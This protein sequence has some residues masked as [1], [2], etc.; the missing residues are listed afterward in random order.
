M[1]V[2]FPCQLGALIQCVS[3]YVN[4]YRFISGCIELFQLYQTVWNRSNLR[5]KF[6]IRFC[7]NKLINLQAFLMGLFEQPRRNAILSNLTD[8]KVISI[9]ASLTFAIC[10]IILYRFLLC[11]KKHVVN[12]K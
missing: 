6:F 11:L 3:I 4:L 12:C 2:V 8:N 1:F 10:D 5:A 9:S 7:N